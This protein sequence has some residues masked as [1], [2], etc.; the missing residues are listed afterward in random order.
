MSRKD[1]LEAVDSVIASIRDGLLD[2]D[3]VSLVGFG[4]FEVKVRN[5]RQGRNPRTS[6]KIAIPPKAMTMF[7]PGKSFREAVNIKAERRDKGG[8]GAA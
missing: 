6:Q 7:R 4:T 8:N 2:G 3:K 5:A 1:A